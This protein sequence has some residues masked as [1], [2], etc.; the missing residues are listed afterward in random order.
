MPMEEVREFFPGHDRKTRLW[1]TDRVAAELLRFA[2]RGDPDRQF[3]KLLDRYTKN[4]FENY[5]GGSPPPIKHEWDGVYRVGIMRFLFRIIGFFDG[6]GTADFIAL[7]TFTKGG[8]KLS[9]S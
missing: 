5:M 3:M 6:P 4:G 9:R 7:D 8:Q 2:R 1:M